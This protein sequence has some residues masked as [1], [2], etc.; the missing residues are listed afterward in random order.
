MNSLVTNYPVA[1]V[2][3]SL[4]K[5][6]KYDRPSVIICKDSSVPIYFQ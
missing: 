2:I 4:A 3:V 6:L 1:I 5:F